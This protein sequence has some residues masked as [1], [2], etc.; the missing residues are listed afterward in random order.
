MLAHNS[1][2]VESSV[3]RFALEPEAMAGRF[4]LA[5]AQKR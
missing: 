4:G 3:S 5:T 2:T 1:I